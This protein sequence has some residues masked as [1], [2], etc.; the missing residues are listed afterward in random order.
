MTGKTTHR[1]I[2]RQIKRMLWTGCTLVIHSGLAN[3][4]DGVQLYGA[5]KNDPNRH[6]AR[7]ESAQSA[8]KLVVNQASN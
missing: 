6:F 2:N 1:P 8:I 3:T 4:T 7:M 5:Q